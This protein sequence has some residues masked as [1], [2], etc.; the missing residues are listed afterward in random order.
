VLHP[1]ATVLVNDGSAA[2]RRMEAEL[3]EFHRVFPAALC[4]SRIVPV[5]EVVT[6]TLFHREDEPLRR[7]MLDE[8]ETAELDQF[9]QELHFVS[10]DAL[11]LV[12]AFAQLM[13]FATQDSN[14]ALF[15]PF[16]KP[17][18]ARADAFRRE[19]LAAEPRQLDALIAFAD[20]AY[21]RPLS[22]AERD[23]LRSLYRQLREQDLPHEEAFRLT[24]ARVFVAP[25]FLY[26]PESAGPGAAPRPV[27]DWELANRLSYFLW[28]SMPDAQLREVAAAGQLRDP[29]VLAEQARRMLVDDRVRRLAVEFACQW[30]HVYDFDALDEKSE[31]HFPNFAALRGDMYEEVIRFFTNLAQQDQSVLDVYNAEYTFV[32]DRLARH[33]GIEGVQGDAWRRVDGV[34]RFGRGGILG[35]AATLAKQS[36][37]SRTSPILR[38]N[39]VSEVLLGEKLPRPP[40]DV[41]RLP[42]DEADTA[43]LSVRQLVE[44]HTSDQRCAGCHA[45]IDPIGFAL[46]GYDAIGGRREQDLA[47]RPIDTNSKLQDGA[48]LEGID[49]LRNYLLTARRDALLRQFCRKLV[50]YAL[51]RGV[52]LSDE[53][54]LDMMRD[55][56]ARKGYRF[57]VA[58]NVIVGSRQF[59]EI[60]GSDAHLAEAVG[61]H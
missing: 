5:D 31:R 14:P 33:Y 30:L 50:G 20:R 28:S 23:E 27:S 42:E 7:L 15:E 26:R 4:Y 24:L 43:G 13:E 3:G 35:F 58:I 44:K 10:N 48:E 29:Q 54:L 49:G 41:P 17:I 1:F 9:W 52:Q 55:E 53:P 11:T 25:A 60:R 34:S 32:N 2:R 47:G 6:L 40:K 61:E 57:S 51:G 37:A 46:E 59:R 39:W 45:R 22:A 16:R 12:D 56:L 38:G 8:R 36:G 19:L 18:H 21:R